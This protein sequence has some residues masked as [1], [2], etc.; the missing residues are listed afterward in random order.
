MGAAPN[1]N[2]P[3][4]RAHVFMRHRK[5]EHC[6]SCSQSFHACPSCGMSSHVRTR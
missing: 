5:Y 4:D 3:F 6:S 2:S 1:S